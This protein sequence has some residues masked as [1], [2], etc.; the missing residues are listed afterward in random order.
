MKPTNSGLAGT[1]GQGKRLL[2]SRLAAHIYQ[3]EPWF[4]REDKE[5][6]SRIF[7][8]EIRD[9]RGLANNA[10]ESGSLKPNSKSFMEYRVRCLRKMGYR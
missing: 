3:R 10:I 1:Q 8:M 2:K 6:K 9:H 7:K 4:A 5:K